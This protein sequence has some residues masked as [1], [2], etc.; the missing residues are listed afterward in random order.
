[1]RR[2][3]GLLLVVAGAW[4]LPAGLEACGDKFLAVSRGTRFQR[5]GLVRRPAAILVIAPPGGRLAASVQA[6][7]LIPALTKVGYTPVVVTGTAEAAS[8]LQQRRWDLVLREID[9]ADPP[10]APGAPLVVVVAWEAPRDAVRRARRAYDGV[11]VRPT[12]ARAVVDAVDDALFARAL[13]P[14][15]AKAGN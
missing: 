7:D 14:A 15:A 6:L 8:A 5:S 9:D 13:R 1:M 3:F 12:K 10:P 11:L 2:G 4:L